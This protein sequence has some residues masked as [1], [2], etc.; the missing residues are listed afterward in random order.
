ML[1]AFGFDS[2]R[3]ESRSY[4]GWWFIIDSIYIKQWEDL[5]RTEL[6]A[7]R[8]VIYAAHGNS[9]GVGHAFVCDGYNMEGKFHFNF[10][11]YGYSNGW[12][13][14][15]AL[16][17]SPRE[18]WQPPTVL[19]KGDINTDGKANIIDLT[20]LIDYLLGGGGTINHDAADVDNKNGV[21]I[22]DLAA[23]IDLLLTNT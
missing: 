13:A 2:V 10:G 7:G 21:T 19:L 3:Y 20:T 18:G 14:S 16:D 9:A 5:L 11:W 23:L 8:P 17:V 22:A 12:F 6:D 4:G 1:I 15:T